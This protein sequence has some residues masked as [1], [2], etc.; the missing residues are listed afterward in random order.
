MK[1]TPTPGRCLIKAEIAEDVSP[2]GVALPRDRE[3]DPKDNPTIGTVVDIGAALDGTVTP[4]V[5][6]GDRVLFTDF[7]TTRPPGKDEDVYIVD[8]DD[9]AAVLEDE[10]ADEIPLVDPEADDG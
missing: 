9:I 10:G 1:L 6:I 8:F 5:K 4:C 7:I 2:G 3:G